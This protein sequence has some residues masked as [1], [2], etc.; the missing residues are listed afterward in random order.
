V[1][2]E[3][4]GNFFGGSIGGLSERFEQAQINS[5]INQKNGIESA[6]PGKD[7]RNLFV[8]ADLRLAGVRFVHGFSPPC[9]D[10]RRD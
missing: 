6:P 1:Q 3:R 4:G 10:T 2:L 9:I 7:F 5:D 8:D